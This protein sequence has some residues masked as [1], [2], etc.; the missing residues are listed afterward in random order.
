MHIVLWIAEEHGQEL[1]FGLRQ[2][3]MFMLTI[4]SC[5]GGIKIMKAGCWSVVMADYSCQEI[6]ELHGQTK[7]VILL[8]NN[9]ILQPFIQTLVVLIFLQEHKIMACIN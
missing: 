2:L 3:L 7:I 9:S 5:N 4:I 1:H 6:M 8:S